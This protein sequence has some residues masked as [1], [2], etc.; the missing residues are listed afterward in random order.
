[1][2]YVNQHMWSNK[3]V[4]CIGE[5]IDFFLNI[6]M[7]FPSFPSF[8][9]RHIVIITISYNAIEVKSKNNIIISITKHT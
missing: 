6:I 7:I 8:Y 3:L 4:F 9:V 2:F 1:M 5:F